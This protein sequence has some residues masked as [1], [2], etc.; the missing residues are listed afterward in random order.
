MDW[1]ECLGSLGAAVA[2]HRAIATE[3]SAWAEGGDRQCSAEGSGGPAVA[4]IPVAGDS[5]EDH[6]GGATAALAA[7]AGLSY[8]LKVT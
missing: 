5:Q 2:K 3:T 4:E 7:A 1:L 6:G 8:D